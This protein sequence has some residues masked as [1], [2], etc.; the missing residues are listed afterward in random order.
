M[1]YALIGFILYLICVLAV[2]LY[3]YRANKSH[4]D[5]FLAGMK[6]NPWVVAFSERASG[7]SAWLLLGLPGAAFA[8]GLLELW[9]A[10]GCSLGSALY[11]LVLA[12]DVRWVT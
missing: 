7:E 8:A 6:L 2:G 9:T 10:V 4:K 1:N 5:F 3:T 12:N 11:G